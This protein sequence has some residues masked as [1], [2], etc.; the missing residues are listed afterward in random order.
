MITSA[1]EPRSRVR[2]VA[3]GA[4][5]AFLGLAL[6]LRAL[7]DGAVEQSSGTALYASMVYAGVVFL[8]PRMRPVVAGA[9]AILFCWVVE[10]AQ[11]TGVPATLSAHSV[12]ARLALG[13]QFD[14]RDLLWY[15]AGVV[16][17]VIVDAWLRRTP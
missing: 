17:I 4:A 7:F 9:V 10:T 16:P 8:A 14:P 11:L 6:A 2:I 1:P 15:P 5:V 3:V 12:V 13:V